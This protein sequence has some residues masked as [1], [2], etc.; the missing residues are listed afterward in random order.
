MYFLKKKKLKHTMC[1]CVCIKEKNMIFC[2]FKRL[3]VCNL[4]KKMNFFKKT[5]YCYFCK[6]ENN[7]FNT[8][9]RTLHVVY[10]SK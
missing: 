4:S 7:S 9:K 8:E 6:R 10:N 1:V 3:V 5:I 2:I